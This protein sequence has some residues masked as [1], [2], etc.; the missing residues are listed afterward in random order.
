MTPQETPS[1]T[2]LPSSTA[3]QPYPAPHR[4]SARSPATATAIRTS[5]S[6]SCAVI[7]GCTRRAAKKHPRTAPDTAINGRLGAKISSAVSAR[8]SCS[9]Y[10]AHGPA[11]TA[12]ATMAVVPKPSAVKHNPRSVS[13]MPLPRARLWAASRADATLMP[14]VAKDTNTMYSARISWYR[15]MPSPPR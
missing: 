9:R 12:C 15:P 4:A 11:S 3:A 5:C 8:I 6:M 1:L 13:A 7:F 2:V 10:R 14:A